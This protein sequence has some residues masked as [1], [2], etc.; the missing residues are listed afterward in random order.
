MKSREG[1]VVF[2]EDL[3]REAEN[4]ALE[5]V[6]EKN[7]ELAE[8]IQHE[9]AQAVG[10]GAIKYPMLARENTKL[11]TFD[12][13]I[14]L[15]I[16]GQAAPYIQYAHVRANSILRRFSSDTPSSLA[17]EHEL[18]S[19]EVKLIDLIARFPEEVARAAQ[20]LKTLHITSYAYETARA[21]N[22]FYN[23]CPVLKAEENV[24]DFR[25][26]LV[27]STKITIANALLLLGIEAPS[28]M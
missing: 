22:E 18:K 16:N 23:E 7:P 15:D 27:E 9:I 13:D 26:R 10:Y 4:R 8:E 14:A 11:V 3:L 2:L 24:R 25:L 1:T 19:S 5:I 28:V 20:D 17:P 6:K 12:W 21:F